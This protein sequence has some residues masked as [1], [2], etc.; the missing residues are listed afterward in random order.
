MVIYTLHLM[1]IYTLHLCR[2][3]KN[4]SIII[5]YIN[6]NFDLCPVSPDCAMPPHK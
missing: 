2:Y 6:F 5:N 3:L 1:V 4:K